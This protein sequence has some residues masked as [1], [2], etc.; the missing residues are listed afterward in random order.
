MSSILDALRKSEH[1]RQVAS[2]QSASMLYP[3]EIKH[4]NKS[5]RLL[6]LLGVT[7]IV[8]LSIVLWIELRPI[9]MEPSI[10][11]TQSSIS[12]KDQP[13]VV[14]NVPVTENIS[15]LRNEKLKKENVHH[16]STQKKI[17]DS[18]KNKIEVKTFPNTESSTKNQSASN[19]AAT[20]DD[21]LKGLPELNIAGYIHNAQTGNLAMI[22]NHLVHEGEEISHGLVLVKILDDKAVFSYNGYVFSR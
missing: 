14:S 15:L 1:D 20:E 16:D 6:T 21:P 2:G 19:K 10:N 4:E 12:V 8:F 17:A 9:P 22:N 5:W 3:I 7:L 11:L 13:L 18:S